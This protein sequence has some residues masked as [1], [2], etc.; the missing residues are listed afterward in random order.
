MQ[1]QVP[2]PFTIRYQDNIKGDITQISNG[3][4]NRYEP[5][6]TEWECT[7]PWWNLDCDEVTVPEIPTSQPYGGNTANDNF[8][9]RYIDID[10]DPATFSS[11]SATLST[12]VNDGCSTVVYAALYWSATYRYNTDNSSSGRATDF[13]LVKLKLPGASAYT[14]ITGTVIYDGFGTADFG[15]NGPYA[16]YADVTSLV[17]GLADPNGEYTVANIRASQA[18]LSGGVSGGWTLFVVYENPNK[19]G[20]YVTSYDGFAG[21]NSGLG[22]IDVNYSGFTTV[23]APLPVRAK[24][25][26]CA[27][28]GDKGINGDRLE[29]KEAAAG[30]FSQLSNTLN[31]ATNFF[32]GSISY[33]DATDAPQP[34]T[35]RVPNSSN[36][37]GYDA[38]IINIPNGLLSNGATAATLRIRYTQDNYYMFFNALSVDIIEPEIRLV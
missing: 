14:D 6:D 19:P 8:D 38:D 13:N 17:A 27:L 30:T 28:E 3:I 5:E 23:P 37:L 26:A 16:C 11:S 31:P 7:G 1:A 2:V 4:V 18:D 15:H 25:M 24:L 20:K 34:F 9:M 21:V 35:N 36:T 32:N 29:F 12:V 22:S 10:G 33:L